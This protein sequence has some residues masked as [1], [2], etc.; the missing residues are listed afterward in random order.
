MFLLGMETTL[1]MGKERGMDPSKCVRKLFYCGRRVGC[2]ERVHL[3]IGLG[4]DMFSDKCGSRILVSCRK[5]DRIGLLYA[6]KVGF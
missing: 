1:C 2:K 3:R 5:E 6:S 4:D